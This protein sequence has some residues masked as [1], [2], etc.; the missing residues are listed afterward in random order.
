MASTK[1]WYVREFNSSRH[2]VDSYLY[3]MEGGKTINTW[4][5][6]ISRAKAWRT[7]KEATAFISESL[8]RGEV[9]GE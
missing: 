7:K 2:V 4:T 6:D 3:W 9:Y 5:T 1:K 8:H